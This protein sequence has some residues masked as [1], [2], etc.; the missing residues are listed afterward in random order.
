M[1]EPSSPRAPAIAVVGA[2]FSGVAAAVAAQRRGA[3]VTLIHG[4]PGASA[5]YS[6]AVDGE[7]PHGGSADGE[8]ADGEVSELASE[9]GLALFREPRPIATREG[10]IREARGSDRALL[11]LTAVAGCRV[12]VVDFGRDDWDARLL[13]RSFDTSDWA[14]RTRTSFV[15]LPVIELAYG[16]ERRIASYDL[17]ARLDDETRSAALAESLLQVGAEVEAFLSG[18]FLGLSGDLPGR[19]GTRLGRPV[20]ETTSHPGGAAG[21]RFELRS[22]A[23]LSRRP[24][25]LLSG[26]VLRVE[27]GSEGYRIELADASPRVASSV[28]LAIGGLSAGGIVLGSSAT[29]HPTRPFALSLDA[30]VSLS[31]DGQILDSTGSPAGVTLEN[32]GLGALE[33]VGIACRGGR[34]DDQRGLFACG[35]ALA[36]RSGSVLAALSSGLLA[37][38]LAAEPA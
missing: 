23:L 31:L 2:G 11:D 8:D 10:G 28:V 14:R 25:E 34:V 7:G 4:R 1:P 35:D 18:P 38:R 33:R 26:R 3:R 27:P 13:A 32:L 37:G 36:A 21:A 9:L 12:G 24:I 16:V 17:A 15:A 22:R 30:P 20:G 29:D 6:G 19:L 5:L